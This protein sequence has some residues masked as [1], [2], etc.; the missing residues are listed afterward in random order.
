MGLGLGPAGEVYVADAG[1][2]RVVVFDSAGRFQRAFGGASHLLNPVDVAVDG[3]QVWVVDSHLHQV[4]AFD[5]AGE[6]V[7]RLGK[8]EATI[9]DRDT[10][11]SDRAATRPGHEGEAP[12]DFSPDD[13]S[14]VWH[15]RGKEPGEFRYPVSVAIGPD[16]TVYVSDQLNF[17]VQ[18]F[19]QDGKFVRQI[20]RLGDQPGT[21]TR[22]KGVAVDSDGHLYVV[23][24]AFSNVQVFDAEGRVLLAFGQLGNGEGEHWLPIGIS[25][26]P[27]NRI[28]V[29]DR[30]NNRVQIYQYLP[31]NE[32]PGAGR[33]PGGE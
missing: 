19:D 23:D 9:A 24:G 25:I 15:N 10:R 1:Q 32:A 6:V 33:A 22:P 26:D 29:A 30:Y 17:R 20:G 21:F 2:R 31:V 16:G 11:R 5:A 7:A 13:L 14:D 3:D 28:F 12:A 18:A 4:L 8:T 27:A